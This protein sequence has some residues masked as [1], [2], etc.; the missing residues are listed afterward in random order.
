MDEKK[1]LQIA[2]QTPQVLAPLSPEEA[3]NMMKLYQ[4][5]QAALLDES[6]YQDIQGKKF[7]KKSAWRKFAMA[8][9]L[10]V[11]VVDER[12]EELPNGDYA[13]HFVAEA[14]HPN[15]RVTSGSGSCTAYEKSKL[16]DGKWKTAKGYEAEANSLHNVRST[17]ET[18]AWNRAV[19]NMVAAGEVSAEEV[20]QGQ[21][22]QEQYLQTTK[23]KAQSTQPT[24]E[25]I[26]VTYQGKTMQLDA[27]NPR[28][29]KCEAPM[30]DNR[31]N[32][33][34]GKYK[35]TSADF[36][37]SDKSCMNGEYRTSVWLSKEKKQEVIDVDVSVEDIPF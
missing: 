20:D 30:W 8:N 18:R 33:A 22:I 34:S 4:D 3:K 17:A 23:Q 7:K 32:K 25:T 12:R 36:S 2:E 1:E 6:D 21:H 13:Y 31:E 11:R 5:Y 15:G 26:E 37:C 9:N 10:S 24:G 19:S 35:P 28:C 14:T 16:I 29:P 27:T